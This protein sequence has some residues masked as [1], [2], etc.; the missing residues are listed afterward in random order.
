MLPALLVEAFRSI[1]GQLG[2]EDSSHK[3]PVG[4]CKTVAAVAAAV[5]GKPGAVGV[6]G[7]VGGTLVGKARRSI[8]AVGVVVVVATAEGAWHNTVEL[9]PELELGLG[10][11]LELGGEPATAAALAVE[12]SRNP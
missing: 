9:G 11:E 5:E 3:A 6:V 2:L 8:A 4:C 12:R 1:G 10:L 7:V